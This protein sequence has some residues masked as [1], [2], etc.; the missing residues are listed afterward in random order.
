MTV[1]QMLVILFCGLLIGLALYLLVRSLRGM[2]KGRCCE[3]CV[4]CQHAADCSSRDP[5]VNER[6]E[7]Q[8][9][10]NE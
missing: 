4:G 5:A 7:R 9:M 1:L 2:A 3:G 6:G 10:R 8:D